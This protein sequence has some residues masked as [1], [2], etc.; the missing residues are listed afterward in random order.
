MHTLKKLLAFVAVPVLLAAGCSTPASRLA[1]DWRGI[2]KPALRAFKPQQPRRLTLPN[3]MLI[4]LQEDHELPLIA[5]SAWIRGGS[6]EEPAAKVGLV[7]IYGQAWR[8]GGSVKRGGDA[9]D[10]Y[11]EMRAAEVET[12]GGTDSTGVSFNCLKEN[13]EEVFPVFEELLRTEP[14][15]PQDKIDLAKRQINTG[16]ARR[17]DNHWEIAGREAAKLVY[18]ADSPYARVPEYDTVKA[19]ARDDLAAW[20]SDHVHP[21]NIILS[22]VGDFDS[23]EMAARLEKSFAAWPS[24][25]AALKLAQSFPGPKPGVYVVE[26]EDV[27]QSN[28]RLVHLGITMDN[29]DYFAIEVM[30]KLFGGGFASRLFTNVRSK[31]GLAYSVWGGVGAAMD[32]PGIFQVAM[33]TKTEGTAAGIDALLEEIDNLSR[34]PPTP[35]ELQRAK[36]GLL[37]S[38]V[39]RF[40][41]KEKVL[42]EQATYAFYGYPPDF[43]DRYEAAVRAVTAADVTRV[44]GKYVRRDKLA[45]LV[46]GKTKDFDRDL[47]SFG[48]VTMIDITIPGQARPGL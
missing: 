45:I 3:G 48:P 1:A 8:A 29:P 26:K 34:N 2:Q 40:D 44:A 27:K 12:W 9:L 20:F 39:F 47:K 16:I 11:L 14:A 25:K 4:L 23:K 36:D 21:N 32:H 5:G 38:F 43:L 18:G 13:F 7:S 19:V 22:I 10:D 30:N 24:G 17:N 15:F 37:N 41:S 33:G 31:K 46:V 42:N 35:V 6:R 28:L